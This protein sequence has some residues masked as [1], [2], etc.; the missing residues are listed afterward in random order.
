MAKIQ[1]TELTFI[2]K[3][4]A[5]LCVKESKR[6]ITEKE[7]NEQTE[8][9]YKR[10]NEITQEYLLKEKE[11]RIELPKPVKNKRKRRKTIKEKPVV[12]VKPQTLYIDK[13]TKATKLGD[14]WGK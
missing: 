5:K 10:R 9:L 3:K 14:F 11:N 1:N 13:P 12:K 6:E 8:K 7:F 4:I 2:L